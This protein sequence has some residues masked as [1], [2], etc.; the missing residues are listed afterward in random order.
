MNKIIIPI[1]GMHCKSC[2]LLI[3]EELSKIPE[4]KK[5]DAIYKKKIAEI[6]YGNQKPNMNEIKEAIRSSGY[7]VGYE[8]AEKKSLV[9]KNPSDYKDLG[10]AFLFLAGLYLI[11]KNF[12]LTNLNF[13]ASNSSP[14]SLSMI[15]LVGL[16]AGVS[17]C[18][19]LVGGLVLGIATR[20]AEKHPEAS[21]IQK[22]R[23]HIYFNLGRILFFALFGGILGSIGSVLQLSGFTLGVITILVGI[24]MLIIGLQLTEIFPFL[25]RIK[26]TLPKFISK[27]VGIKKHQ[28]EYSHKN[29]MLIGSL[30]FFLPCGFT[31]AMQL[32]AISTG[33]FVSG[34]LA[35]GIFA[36]GTAPGLLGVGG[37]TSLVKGIFAK[38]FFKF[39]GL[40][41]IFFSLFNISNGYNLTGFQIGSANSANS[42]S[43]QDP[44]VVLENGVQVVKMTQ[45]S[46]GYSPN[47]F[48]VKKGVPVKW[49]INSENPNSCA[50]SIILSKMNIS[51]RL[52]GGEN[53]IEFTPTDVGALKFS[54]SMGM[55]TGVFNVVDDSGNGATQSELN[56]A[57][58]SS[59]SCGGGAAASSA[60]GANSGGSCGAAGGGCGGC[61]GG[62]QIKKDTADTIA[63]VEGDT[64]I[65]NTTY[66]ASNYLQPNSFKVKAGTKVKFTIDVK[67]SGQG[68]GYAIIIPSLYNNAIPLQA[69]VPIVMEFTPTTRGSFNITCSMGMINYGTI[70]VE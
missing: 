61:G 15:F 7:D 23:P 19:A 52:S 59:G 9:N 2:E 70:V 43:S 24:V 44:N 30:T 58:K 54:C 69:G 45:G 41:V 64:Q 35:M 4:I 48:T 26:L 6:Y 50:S 27:S 51:K 31:Q 57:A 39:A 60:S 32:Y 67:D 1:T 38:R 16:T 66:T 63:K 33:S 28:G 29:S 49:V 10:I 36:L 14:S 53:I 5:A 11:L 62:T 21:A 37:L 8:D 22:F 46:R 65:I 40:L 56:S 68:C 34:A 12:G 47:Q 3:E 20:H 25:S 17:T 42:V 13:A 18:M 55:Y